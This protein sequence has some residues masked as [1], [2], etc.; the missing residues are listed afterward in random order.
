MIKWLVILCLQLWNTGRC[1]RYIV[2]RKPVSI[3]WVGSKAGSGCWEKPLKR[4]KLRA[5]LLQWDIYWC[6]TCDCLVRL[7]KW[8][9]KNGTEGV[10]PWGHRALVCHD[11]NH[12]NAVF[13]FFFD[14]VW[15]YKRNPGEMFHMICQATLIPITW[16]LHN[17]LY[18]VLKWFL[19]FEK[20]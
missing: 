12:P 5:E 14:G 16:N 9:A 11:L 15:M 4:H 19:I 17:V 10:Q 3:L 13:F 20:K 1:L 2:I 8:K 18:V 7:N 6:R